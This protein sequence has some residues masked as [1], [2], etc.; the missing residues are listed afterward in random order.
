MRKCSKNHKLWWEIN[1]FGC[2]NDR[3]WYSLQDLNLFVWNTI[4][5]TI[6]I[7]VQFCYILSVFCWKIKSTTVSI[8][9][10]FHDLKGWFSSPDQYPVLCQKLVPKR[11]L[12]HLPIKQLMN[13]LGC[14]MIMILVN[15]IR[16][17]KIEN[18]E[19]APKAP[20]KMCV[21]RVILSIFVGNLRIQVNLIQIVVL[22][23]SLP[24]SSRRKFQRNANQGI[25]CA[26]PNLCRKYGTCKLAWVR[27]TGLLYVPSNHSPSLPT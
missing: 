22:N 11:R 3:E 6:E 13:C 5:S 23:S 1:F 18:S 2:I 9:I 25:N 27:L 16:K 8:P 10:I 21:F 20:K 12:W 7:L 24:P 14:H 26:W 17:F 15:K 19:A 4:P